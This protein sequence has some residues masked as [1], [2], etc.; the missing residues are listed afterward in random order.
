[1]STPEQ[2]AEEFYS[3]EASI[4]NR[5]VRH[6]QP[7]NP[8]WGWSSAGRIIVPVVPFDPAG[9]VAKK[10]L[11][12]IG[13]LQ[14]RFPKPGYHTV[15][16]NLQQRRPPIT[17][18][19]LN[20]LIVRAGA[21]IIWT[22]QGNAVRRVIDLT[23]GTSISGTG[24]AC[25]VD[26][27]DTS[28]VNLV[29]DVE[30]EYDISVQV[31]PGARPQLAGSQPPLKNAEVGFYAAGGNEFEAGGS[32]T[33]INPAIAPFLDNRT[34][35]FIPQNCGINSYHLNIATS[36]G[37]TPTGDDLTIAQNA[38]GP[39]V[40]QGIG[41]VNYDSL[42]QWNPLSPGA[43]IITIFNNYEV[44]DPSHLTGFILFGVDG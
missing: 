44:V 17:D 4:Y 32:F 21:E 25:N 16:F 27:F 22:V 34:S 12:E 9:P 41:N 29:T 11:V 40:F 31:T 8:A 35:I 10:P 14:I 36:L 24:E 18:S 28:L 43:K 6:P 30:Y 37:V 7:V 42:N 2:E 33:I 19:P 39:G 3:D 15:Q 1:M 26:I 20:P 5:R 13:P 23:D 38:G